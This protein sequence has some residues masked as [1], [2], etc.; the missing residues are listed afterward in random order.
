M[1]HGATYAHY[2]QPTWI[3]TVLAT[4]LCD[5]WQCWPC[6]AIPGPV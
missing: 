1:K 2:H 4:V 3:S 6:R 5:S